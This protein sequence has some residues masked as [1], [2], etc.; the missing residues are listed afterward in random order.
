MTN[1]KYGGY[2]I[3]LDGTIYLG[4]KRIPA[5]ENFI[6]RLQEAKIPYLL[7]TNN[8]TK[9]PRVVQKRLSQHF[10]IE[11]PLETIYTASLATVDYMN[12][13]GLEKTVYIIGEDGLKE[14]IYEAGYKKDRENPAYVVVALDTDLTYEMLV[15]ATLAIHKGAKFIGT[16]PDLNL[17]NERGLTPG[18]GA[19]IK[20]LEAATRVEA[21]IIGKPEAIIADKAVEKLGLPK[22]DLLMVGDNYLTDIHTGINNGIDSL[23][24]LPK[25]K[26]YQIFQ[27]RQLMWCLVWTSGKSKLTVN[28]VI[29]F[30]TYKIVTDHFISSSCRFWFTV[31]LLELLSVTY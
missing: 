4:N 2:L 20:M 25:L 10:N 19:L 28:S 22:S 13:L 29:N 3:D 14:A 26:K 12:D 18:A 31:V 11:T 27:F 7:V 15:L 8:T 6:H 21:T 24:D 9:T 1:K 16:N 30:M 5:G 17:P 23:L